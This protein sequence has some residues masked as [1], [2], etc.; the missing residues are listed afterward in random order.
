MP[1]D[2]VIEELLG[3]LRP[4]VEFHNNGQVWKKTAWKNAIE[5]QA[6]LFDHKTKRTITLADFYRAQRA[7]FNA[8][9]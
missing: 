4:F 6:V 5:D 8:A 3:A 1:Q 7:F 9:D 2:D